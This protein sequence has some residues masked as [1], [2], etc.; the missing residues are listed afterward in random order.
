MLAFAPALIAVC[1]IVGAAAA[2]T[3]ADEPA[4][5]GAR[6]VAGEPEA[7][8][9][10]GQDD[11]LAAMMGRG[12]AL[13]GG[14]TFASGSVERNSL[15]VSYACPG[16]TVVYLLNHPGVAAADAQRT[17]RFALKLSA[18]APPVGLTEALVAR[19][20]ERE[21]NFEWLWPRSGPRAAPRFPLAPIAVAVFAAILIWFL[22]RRRRRSAA[23]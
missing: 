23:R 22:V 3:P 12:A 10:A 5:P 16:G 21:R 7:V 2:R 9:P 19:I 15:T 11:F 17:E 18:G 14:C 6:A 4:K 1:A 13:P 20:R 8:F